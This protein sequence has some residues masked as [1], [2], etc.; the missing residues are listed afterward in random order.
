MLIRLTTALLMGVLATV[1][2]VGAQAGQQPVRVRFAATVGETSLDCGGSIP[3]LDGVLAHYEAGSRTIATGQYAGI[4][5]NNPLKS[6]FVKGFTPTPDERADLKAFLGS[7]T[8]CA[9]VTDPRFSN[10]WPSHKK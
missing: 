9:F 2:H 4:G 10:P 6:S 7:L 5:A 3:T 8:D 1:A